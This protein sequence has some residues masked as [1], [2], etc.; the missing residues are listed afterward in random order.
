ME[1]NPELVEAFLKAHVELTHYIIEN[2]EEAAIIANAQIEKITGSKLKEED[3]L[4]ASEKIIV[5]YDPSEKSI[6]SFIDIYV[7]ENFVS[8]VKDRHN[9]CDFSALNKVL[10]EKGL[11]E[12]D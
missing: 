2:Q 9:I 1:K 10:R 4:A 5:T 3:L 8:E 7:S 6:Q 11:A 12:I